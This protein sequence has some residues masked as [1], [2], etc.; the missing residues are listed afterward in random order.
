[1]ATGTATTAIISDGG[2]DTARRTDRWAD[3]QIGIDDDVE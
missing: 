1:M 2:G 3:L